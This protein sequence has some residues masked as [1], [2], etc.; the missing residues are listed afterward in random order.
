M[1]KLFLLSALISLTSLYSATEPFSETASSTGATGGGSV[2]EDPFLKD[3]HKE[4]IASE[5]AAARDPFSEMAYPH[6][7][8]PAVVCA[9]VVPLR[10]ARDTQLKDILDRINEREAKVGSS[11]ICLFDQSHPRHTR[12]KNI[13]EIFKQGL[14]AKNSKDVDLN[15]VLSDMYHQLAPADIRLRV[16]HVRRVSSDAGKTVFA[17]DCY[18]LDQLLDWIQTNLT[19]GTV[20]AEM[21]RVHLVYNLL[22]DP[23][24]GSKEFMSA[25]CKR[26]LGAE[27]LAQKLFAFLQQKRAAI[28]QQD[29][30]TVED[31]VRLIAIIGQ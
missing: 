1:K 10:F 30:L 21:A 28:V 29:S 22:T 19:E 20:I 3:V 14:E 4:P 8:A 27:G 26:T 16:D 5:N 24:W 31:C 13:E 9:I 2:A 23:W 15:A 25:V 11:V 12:W 7:S 6:G 17:Y 18:T